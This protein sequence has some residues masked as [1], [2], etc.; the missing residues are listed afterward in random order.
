MSSDKELKK[1]VLQELEFDTAVDAN[2]IGVIV[3]DGAVT[4]TGT[5]DNYVQRYSAIQA[6]KRVAGVKAVADDINIVLSQLHRRDDSEIAKHIAHVFECN[7]AIPVDSVKAE[8]R[9]GHITLTGKVQT[10]K[11]R[12]NIEKQVAHVAG[13]T[14]IDNQISI[15]QNSIAN[16]V[17]NQICAALKRNAE[18]EAERVSIA[19]EGHKVILTGRVKSFYERELAQLAAWRAKGVTKVVDKIEVG[20]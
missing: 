20:Q 9:Q 19:V 2:Q 10:E 17:H 4:L 1:T 13:V 6:V 7:V 12:R 15:E 14:S 8:V 16:D 5:I 18:L 3:D 11:T